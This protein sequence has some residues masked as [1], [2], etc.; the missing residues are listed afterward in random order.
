M[1]TSFI[2]CKVF[3]PISLGIDRSKFILDISKLTIDVDKLLGI[4]VAGKV[5]KGCYGDVDVAVKLYHGAP[6][7]AD[8]M[9]QQ[10]SIDKGYHTQE[11]KEEDSIY[12]NYSAYAI[13]ILLYHTS[14]VILHSSYGNKQACKVLR[15]LKYRRSCMYK[16]L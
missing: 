3:I 6:Q 8:A 2:T 16:H 10:C 9:I 13:Y 14:V 4:G 11:D 1:L 5:L 12:K 15:N 7:M